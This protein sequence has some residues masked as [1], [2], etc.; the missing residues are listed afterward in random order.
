M[1]NQ[2]HAA[3]NVCGYQQH[4]HKC[5]WFAVRSIIHLCKLTTCTYASTYLMYCSFNLSPV[6]KFLLIIWGDTFMNSLQMWLPEDWLKMNISSLYWNWIFP[7]GLLTMAQD[8]LYSILIAS[9]MDNSCVYTSFHQHFGSITWNNVSTGSRGVA[10]RLA[11]DAN[12]KQKVLFSCDFMSKVKVVIKWGL[13][14][15]FC[16]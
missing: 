15:V 5:G 2:L 7:T 11:C 3:E 10:R 8:T 16:K 9:V 13:G 4:K 12:T 1:S 14:V 6:G